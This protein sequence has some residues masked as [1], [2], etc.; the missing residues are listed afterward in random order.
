MQRLLQVRVAFLQCL[1]ARVFQPISD[2]GGKIV[3]S[4]HLG[5]E[6]AADTLPQDYA[7]WTFTAPTQQQCAP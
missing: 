5:I 1:R 6:E 3:G 2:P 7:I 4:T